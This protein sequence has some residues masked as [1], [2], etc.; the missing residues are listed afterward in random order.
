MSRTIKKRN[1]PV[2]TVEMDIEKRFDTIVEVEK[3]N[4]FHDA[5]GRFSNKNGFST[6]SA[7]PNTKAGA[8]AISRSAA[9]GH[10]NTMNVHRDSYGENITQN[11]NWLGRGH[12]ASP[13]AQGSA[14]LRRRVEPA[15][16]LGG[17]SATGASWQH[18]NQAAGRK[19]H[20]SANPQQQPQSQPQTQ[21]QPKPTKPAQPQQPQQQPTQP[22]PQQTTPS[23]S[24]LAASVAN[25]QLSTSDKMAIQ[26]RAKYGSSTVNT[27]NLVKD[28]DQDRVA[29]KDISKT[30]DLQ[31][32]KGNQD[33]I[34]K[35]KAIQGWDKDPTVT[36]DLE[37]FQK[38]AKKSG[39][40]MMRTV[41]DNWQTGQSGEDVCR[42]V[43]GNGKAA[44]GGTGAQAYG[45]GLYMVGA[46]TNNTTGR[47]LG[48]QIANSQSHSFAY[49]DKQM[50]ATVDP[51]AK[52][53][54]PRTA[55]KLRN[56]YYSLS[57]SDQARF[58]HDYGAYIA[59]KGYD[60]AQW[61][62]RSDPYI[63]MYNKSAL[64]FYSGVSGY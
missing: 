2:E 46:K 48:R 27:K 34:D 53:A 60:G 10:G 49:G 47:A 18:Q 4:P 37:V 54:G 26:P 5:R 43:M 29:G 17:A 42:E 41:H 1:Q 36:S 12:Q 11:A 44:L 3:F 50:M 31:K 19:T 14:T 32:V 24:K 56:E 23:S 58:G 57:Y 52:I 59:S 9:A 28:H 35:M 7:N 8:M 25:V 16:G 38:A 62:Q 6:Y 55:A 30:V 20:Q 61:H 45:S 13:N 51:K 21:P 22:T 64:I 33:P 63:T 40:M 39:L 15:A